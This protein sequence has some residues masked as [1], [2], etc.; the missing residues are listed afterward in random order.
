MAARLRSKQ[1]TAQFIF[2]TGHQKFSYVHS[3]LK[4]EAVDYL[5]KPF[6]YEDLTEC[7][8]KVKIRLHKV[9]EQTSKTLLLPEEELRVKSLYIKRA[10]TFVREHYSH[11]LTVTSVARQLNISE[12]YFCR[13]FKKETGYTFVNYLTHYR[14]HVAAGLLKNYSIMV[15]EAAE[16][17]GYTDAN[18]FSNTFKR[19]MNVSPS[20]YQT[21]NR[22]W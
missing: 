2:L 15:S 16:Q 22:I 18:Y 11:E 10:L 17:V 19:I 14:I 5:L 13:L 7:I 4:L 12:E 1:C 6:R 20:E 8:R 3:A 21:L 9:D